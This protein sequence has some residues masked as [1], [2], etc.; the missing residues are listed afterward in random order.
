MKI[1]KKNPNNGA[2][3][4]KK[5]GSNVSTQAKSSSSAPQDVELVESN[6]LTASIITGTAKP[7]ANG[8][9]TVT[10]DNDNMAPFVVSI[11]TSG[12]DGLTS[13]SSVLELSSE[14]QAQI[15]NAVVQQQQQQQ[16]Q[17]SSAEGNLTTGSGTTFLTTPH[18]FHQDPSGSSPTGIITMQHQHQDLLNVPLQAGHYYTTTPQYFTTL[19]P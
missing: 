13:N 3:S 1:H 11:V 6:D 4:T 15:L 16:Q 5:K 9:M 10:L 12:A 18:H 17:Q 8:T 7:D 19:D 2:T 14:N